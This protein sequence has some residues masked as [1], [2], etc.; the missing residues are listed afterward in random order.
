M[1]NKKYLTILFIFVIMILLSGCQK[2]IGIGSK[3]LYETYYG[4][5]INEVRKKAPVFIDMVGS[6]GDGFIIVD[7]KG[8]FGLML[9][10]RQNQVASL[11]VTYNPSYGDKKQAELILNPPSDAKCYESQSSGNLLQEGWVYYRCKSEK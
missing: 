7:E 10:L 8:G 1:K 4:L 2:K 11:M 5:N 9:E 6:D 3:N